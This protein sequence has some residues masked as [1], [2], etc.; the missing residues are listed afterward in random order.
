MVCKM[1]YPISNSK[2]CCGTGFDGVELHGANGINSF[3]LDATLLHL[4]QTFTLFIFHGSF[5]FSDA[6]PQA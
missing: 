1:P 5:M 2:L 6:H 4:C 3:L